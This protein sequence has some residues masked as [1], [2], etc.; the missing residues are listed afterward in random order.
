M[1]TGDLVYC[2]SH[3]VNISV[4][5]LG[6]HLVAIFEAFL[7]LVVEVLGVLLLQQT[8][9][10]VVVVIRGKCAD[11]NVISLIPRETNVVKSTNRM[12]FINLKYGKLAREFPRPLA[13]S[14]IPG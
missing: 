12:A 6:C 3:R 5:S 13:G 2:L 4:G 10:V 8:L 14:A 7:A 1:Y 9:V 11:K